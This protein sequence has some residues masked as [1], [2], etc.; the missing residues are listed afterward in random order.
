[1]NGEAQKWTDNVQKQNN[2]NGKHDM[3]KKTDNMKR[4]QI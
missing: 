2:M 1:M 4:I 3:S